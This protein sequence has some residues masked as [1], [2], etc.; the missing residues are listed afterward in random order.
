MRG[1]EQILIDYL[2][3]LLS[4]ARC[5]VM[6]VEMI[7]TREKLWIYKLGDHVKN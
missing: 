2:I 1:T 7:L 6:P 3:K 4:R 5:S